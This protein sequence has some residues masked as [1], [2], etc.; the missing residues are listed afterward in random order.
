MLIFVYKKEETRV[1]NL[2]VP[3]PKVLKNVSYQM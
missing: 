2:S 1:F 3:I